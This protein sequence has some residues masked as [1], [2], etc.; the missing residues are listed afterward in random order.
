MALTKR[1]KAVIGE[2]A[3]GVVDS[4]T[5]LCGLSKE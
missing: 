1:Q 2:K 4:G 5:D 3:K